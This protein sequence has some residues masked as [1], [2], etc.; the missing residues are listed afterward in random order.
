MAGQVDLEAQITSLGA[1]LGEHVDRA[2]HDP[3]ID[4]LNQPEPL[5][6]I[7]KRS[8]RDVVAVVITHPQQQLILGR[9]AALE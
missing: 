2:G 4:L 1:L 6:D 7:E 8:G 5:G 9:A 3:A